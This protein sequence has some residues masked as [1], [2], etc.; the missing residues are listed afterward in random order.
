MNETQKKKLKQIAS[1]LAKDIK[2]GEDLSDL[3]SHLVRLT[4]EAALG[5][6]MQEHL[7]YSPHSPAG[8]NSGNNRNGTTPKTLK[9]SHGEVLIETPRDR[10]GGFEPQI[11]RKGSNPDYR[12]G[13][14]DSLPVCQRDVNAG[15]RCGFC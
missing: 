5:A 4:V 11:I 15:N 13:R 7:G 3:S 6:E 12:D 2:T 14:A 10:N 8:Y 9:G 1:E